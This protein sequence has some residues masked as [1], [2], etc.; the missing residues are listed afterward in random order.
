ML[1]MMKFYWKFLGR[2]NVF[3]FLYFL[4]FIL[5]MTGVLLSNHLDVDMWGLVN[6]TLSDGNSKSASLLVVYQI[7]I[8]PM[9]FYMRQ[10]VGLFDIFRLHKHIWLLPA[11]LKQ[12][13]VS[14]I[15][16]QMCSLVIIVLTSV[17][18]FD[19]G[20]IPLAKLMGIDT[21]LQTGWGLA[22]LVWHFKWYTLAFYLWLTTLC[23][24]LGA[25][26]KK[27]HFTILIPMALIAL[28]EF[29]F[30]EMGEY[31]HFM[32]YVAILF[33]IGTVCNIRFGYRRF[34]KLEMTL[35]LPQKAI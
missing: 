8:L 24:Y 13:Y 20:R 19:W 22:V 28:Y 31:F 5:F 16:Y 6:G 27:L 15:I 11:S 9:V 23:F 26:F 2:F 21:P 14:R 32:P 25:C 3:L 35:Q 10:C 29:L 7:I 12:K 33:I 4:V 1:K 18:V 34:Q 30:L 17:I